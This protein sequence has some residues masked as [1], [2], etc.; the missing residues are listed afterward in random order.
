MDEEIRERDRGRGREGE[1]ER[2]RL[3]VEG[4]EGRLPRERAVWLGNRRR[5][6]AETERNGRLDCEGVTGN[7]MWM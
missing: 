7:F 5:E 4:G 1:S 3:G 2:K 6:M